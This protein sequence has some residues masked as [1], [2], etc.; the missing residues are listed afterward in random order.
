M[1]YGKKGPDDTDR[2]GVIRSV[3]KFN[4]AKAQGVTPGSFTDDKPADPDSPSWETPTWADSKSF[5][6]MYKRG[7]VPMNNI[8]AAFD[9]GMIG[10]SEMEYI[11]SGVGTESGP[12]RFERFMRYKDHRGGFWGGLENFGGAIT[13]AFGGR[14]LLASSSAILEGLK[15][16]SGSASLSTSAVTGALGVIRKALN[17]FEDMELDKGRDYKTVGVN[18]GGFGLAFSPEEFNRAWHGRTYWSEVLGRGGWDPGKG[19]ASVG[20]A[21]GLIFDVMLDP[22]TWVTLGVKAVSKTA[23]NGGS[24]A[25]KILSK[26]M[27]AKGIKGADQILN[28]GSLTLSARGEEIMQVAGRHLINQ[29]NHS[30]R[31]VKRAS[32]AGS[33]KGYWWNKGADGEYALSS[34]IDEVYAAHGV[35]AETVAPEHIA[36]MMQNPSFKNRFT[37][38]VIENYER[39]GTEHLD[40]MRGGASDGVFSKVQNVAR[41]DIWTPRGLASRQ[42]L[43]R[44]PISMF[45]ET[46]GFLGRTRGIPIDN[47]LGALSHGFGNVEARAAERVAKGEVE[48]ALLQAT[49]LQGWTSGVAHG[50]TEKVRNFFTAAI[51]RVPF[52]DR[53][54][55]QGYMDTATHQQASKMREIQTYFSRDISFTN[56]VGHKITRQISAKER[57]FISH[58]LEQPE[59]YKLPDHLQDAADWARRQFDEI[60]ENEKAWGIAGQEMEDYVTHIY[61]G[62]ALARRMTMLKDLRQSGQ[63]VSARIAAESAPVHNPFALHRKIATLDDA[64]EWFG[65]DAVFTDVGNILHRRAAVSARL[66]AKQAGRYHIVSKYGIGGLASGFLMEGKGFSKLLRSVDYH[67]NYVDPVSRGRVTPRQL[68]RLD[69]TMRQMAKMDLEAMAKQAKGHK[70]PLPKG[71]GAETNVVRN[72]AGKLVQQ[73]FIPAGDGLLRVEKQ[74]FAEFPDKATLV[75]IKAGKYADRV[76]KNRR[77]LGKLTRAIYGKKVQHLTDGEADFLLEYLKGHMNPQNLVGRDGK[78]LRSSW[79]AKD[80]MELVKI[81]SGVIRHQAMGFGYHPLDDMSMMPQRLQQ[82]SR[83]RRNADEQIKRATLELKVF[84]KMQEFREASIRVSKKAD[85]AAKEAEYVKFNDELVAGEWLDDLGEELSRAEAREQNIKKGALVLRANQFRSMEEILNDIAAIGEIIEHNAIAALTAKQKADF[86]FKKIVEMNKGKSRDEIVEELSDARLRYKQNLDPTRDGGRLVPMA[87]KIGFDEART[88]RSI[89]KRRGVKPEGKLDGKVGKQGR[90]YSEEQMASVLD[91]V[92]AKRGK[93]GARF[94]DIERRAIKRRADSLKRDAKAHKS[95][96]SRLKAQA[97]PGA[98]KAAKLAA[99]KLSAVKA[100][101]VKLVRRINVVNRKEAKTL[102]SL[103]KKI[104]DF[105]AKAERT[106][107]RIIKTQL[108]IHKVRKR[109][110]G[111]KTLKRLGETEARAIKLLEA[112][113]AKVA[114]FTKLSEDAS[115][116]ADDLRAAI[117]KEVKENGERLGKLR[118]EDAEAAIKAGKVTRANELI[119]LAKLKEAK[120]GPLDTRVGKIREQQELLGE[121]ISGVHM[122]PKSLVD[123]VNNMLESGFDM[124]N[125]WHRGLKAYQKF[126]K[127]W[128]TPLTIPFPEHHFRNSLTNIG[129]TATHIGLRMLDPRI[130]RSAAN[131]TGYLLFKVGANT[132]GSKKRL[133]PKGAVRGLDKLAARA[134]K[135]WEKITV[136]TIDGVELTVAEIAMEALRRGINHGFVHSELGFSPFQHF[137][138]AAEGT[139]TPALGFV[140]DMMKGAGARGLGTIKKGAVAT[141]TVFDV[142][143][144]MALFTDEVLQGKSYAEAAETVRRQLNDWTRLGKKEQR[145]MRTAVPFYS[146]FQFS[147]ERAFKDMIATP[148]RFVLPFKTTQAAQNVLMDSEPPPDYEP[149]FMSQRLGIWSAPNENGYYS[150][151]VGFGLNQEEAYRQVAAMTDFARIIAHEGIGL[152]S[153]DAAFG[154]APPPRADE[155]GLRVLAQMDFMTKSTIEMMHGKQ[156][157]DGSV[158]GTQ[159][160]LLQSGRSRL[161][162]GKGWEDID[163]G[164]V[165]GAKNV[166]VIG[167]VV[168]GAGGTWLK[169]WLEFKNDESSPGGARVSA[170]KRWIL[171]QTPISRFLSGYERSVKRKR[172]GEVNYLKVALHT[173]GMSI[174]KFHPQEGKYYRDRARIKAVANMFRQGHIIEQ[175]SWYY[176]TGFMDDPEDQAVINALKRIENDIKDSENQ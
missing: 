13:T 63:Q 164:F 98:A 169:E 131:V 97:G 103:D 119:D 66:V 99:S 159:S 26:N 37:G 142:P 91:E 116:A 123:T 154:F 83:I 7:T 21:R 125:K 157:F 51:E 16:S 58:H 129:L 176:T 70:R 137:D 80:A 156:F 126:Q 88:A 43:M 62:K 144:R 20:F 133:L 49:K 75:D 73:D 9:A 64:V 171:G 136:T 111:P 108:K 24:R 25:A 110:L 151:L 65:A 34:F 54:A 3:P 132:Y 160:E 115:K 86:A 18:V 101:A 163:K 166:G 56:S 146:W 53:I 60:F 68:D 57:Q 42:A 76:E 15:D 17:P 89:L 100:A 72:D 109:P 78:P 168:Q 41:G 74:W 92:A 36:R 113:E 122:I 29:N 2:S 45:E 93:R 124:S 121:D 147:L 96:A 162:Q 135:D 94:S 12:N 170:K 104:E 87:D 32:D 14:F 82:A 105:T 143:F 120:A 77:Q 107:E 134:K 48:G 155:A 71:K 174:Y 1:G 175:G 161:E 8:R 152:V 79:R 141:E 22:G 5:D 158:T 102:R 153:K 23:V 114:D 112:Q 19:L 117:G 140:W 145:Y 84:D 149:K 148:G 38:W 173:L 30:A 172:P 10:R 69:E 139:L 40:L 81:E 128:K 90:R 39:F 150:K 35:N 33:V 47:T 52:E 11:Q 4:L 165:H 118:A 130:W 61:N 106:T 28:G 50:A 44:G 59:L 46:A 138:K 55:L 31:L 167:A 6:A 67:R 27:A 95:Q 127:I 85:A